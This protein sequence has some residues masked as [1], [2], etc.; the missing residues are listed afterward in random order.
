MKK[1]DFLYV[2]NRTDIRKKVEDICAL[3]NFTY[4]CLETLDVLLE[5]GELYEK[6]SLVLLSATDL[7]NQ[8][9]IAGM[10]QVTKQISPDAYCI[11]CISQKV[12]K[13]QLQFIKKSGADLVILDLEIETSCKMEFVAT[14][15]L[16]AAYL[17]V[18]VSELALDSVVPLSLYHLMP[19]NRKFLPFVRAGDTITE[20]RI[21]QA[22]NVTE[23]YI[24]REEVE[25]WIQ[26]IQEHQDKSA[27]GV[28]SRCRSQF[29]NLSAAFIELALNI[30]DQSEGSSFEKG[31]SLYQNCY[32]LA[33]DLLMNLSVTED[34]WNIINQSAVFN[35]GPIE[36]SPAIAC[37]VGLTAL[38]A[39]LKDPAEIMIATLLMDLGLLDCNQKT[40]LSINTEQFEGL[41]PEDKSAYYQHPTVGLNKC[42]SRKL[43]LPERVQNIISKTHEQSNGK[44]F[45]KK[46]HGEN[47]PPEAF[48][49][50]FCELIDMASQIKLGRERIDF[51]EAVKSVFDR[52]VNT[53][54]R[55]PAHLLLT[56]KNHLP[57]IPQS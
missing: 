55:I 32:T 35:F 14:Q 20:K 54:S 9:E 8:T 12:P 18:K 41:H 24:K 23:L 22:G 26:Y 30:T 3:R 2:G 15:V 1:I 4:E 37:Y 33:N 7:E 13:D 11:V 17:P 48:L 34:A 45:P 53:G 36:R 16:K 52:E 29:L 38:K 57:Q 10:I 42:L 49:I 44:G 19:L 5:N 21:E 6:T 31:R 51:A 40:I 43:P 50:Q 27:K 28:A 46:V 39:G 25:K 56:W 47:V